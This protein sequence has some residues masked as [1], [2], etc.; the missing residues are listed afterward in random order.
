MAEE[1]LGGA[2]FIDSHAHLA[3]DAFDSDRDEFERL[4][5]ALWRPVFDSIE[6]IV[7]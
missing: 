1:V 6:E 5:L 7:R 4:S 2:A 3:D